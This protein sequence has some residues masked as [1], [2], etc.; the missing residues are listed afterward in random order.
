MRII[1]IP[2]F[3]EDES[4]FEKIQDKL[5]S[6]KLFLS[7]WKLLPNK[8]VKTLNASVFARELV[9]RFQ[10]SKTDFIVGHST[11][12]WVA[13]HIKNIVDCH[14]V[15][16]AS[17]TGKRKVLVPITNRHIIYFV[18]KIGLFFNDFTSYRIV[19]KYYQY[20]PSREIF[21]AVFAKLIKGNRANVI[22][23]LRLIFNPYPSKLLVQPDLSI[24]AREDKI[25]CFPDGS[26]HEVEGDHFSLYTHPEQ[27]YPPI[28]ELIKCYAKE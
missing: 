9:K 1:L 5:P 19:K 26:V 2:G 13:L 18:A 23:Q 22:N 4:I 25:V 17:W 28:V 15:Q 11:G 27:V 16:I 10:I 6:E 21:K 3:G 24:H 12:G 20:K 14:I 7:L 8:S